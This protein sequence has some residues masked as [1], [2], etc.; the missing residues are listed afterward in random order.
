MK[1][2]DFNPLDRKFWPKNPEPGFSAQKNRRVID[3]VIKA[4]DKQQQKKM[5]EFTG[6]L[7]ERTDAAASYLTGMGG[8]H[9][10][11]SIEKYFGKEY[12]MKLR[13]ENIRNKLLQ[14]QEMIITKPEVK[15]Q[16]KK[17]QKK[18]KSMA[19]KRKGLKIKRTLTDEQK[20]KKSK[21]KL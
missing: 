6:E 1:I 10:S 4:Y 14:Q 12:L 3:E 17:I 18:M 8:A 7:R 21:K 13:G 16:Q 19:V 11:R 15:Y 5:K 9:R 20:V 2:G